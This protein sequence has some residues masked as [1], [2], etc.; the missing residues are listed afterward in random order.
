[1]SPRILG[2]E[3]IRA[4][5]GAVDV[6]A[7]MERAFAAYSAGRAVIPPV[8]ELGFADPPGDHDHVLRIGQRQLMH[9]QVGA[10]RR[11]RTFQSC[12]VPSFRTG[13]SS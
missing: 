7:E 1:M 8:G 6:V 4:A 3:E 9:A 13:A 10:I 2:V 11:R 5:L 12:R